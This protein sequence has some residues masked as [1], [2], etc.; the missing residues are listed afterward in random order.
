MWSI[1]VVAYMLLSSFKPFYHKDR[2]KMVDRIML[3]HFTLVG[4]IWD[5]VS[6]SAKDFVSHLLV[7]DPGKRMDAEMALRHEW[8]VKRKKL[9]NETI[10]EHIL[11]SVDDSLL[12][13]RQTSELKKLALMIIAHQSTTDEILQLRKVFG[14]LD[15]ECNGVITFEEF[16]HGLSTM[17]FSDDVVEEIF[18]S[19]V[20]L[21][22]VTDF[23][24]NFTYLTFLYT[25]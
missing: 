4:P 15:T 24:I 5:A 25:T 16:K 19:V 6:E 7:V 10:P 14:E 17:R 18:A 13:Y 1:G 2:R 11:L 3:A 20:S 23:L 22:P 21:C 9:P 8:I 12:R